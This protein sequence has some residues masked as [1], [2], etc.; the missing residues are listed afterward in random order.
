MGRS[1]EVCWGAQSSELLSFLTGMIPLRVVF[2]LLQMLKCCCTFI[3][4][5]RVAW[6]CHA[7]LLS[8]TT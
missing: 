2:L 8:S 4:R 1:G 3:R 7:G 6:A 5:D